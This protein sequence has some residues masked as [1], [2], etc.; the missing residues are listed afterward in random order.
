MAVGVMAVDQGT[1]STRAIIF[2]RSGLPIAWEQIEHRQIFPAP[3]WV[4]HDPAEIWN[5][6]RNVMG[7]ALAKSDLGLSDIAAVGITQQRETTLVWDKVSGNPVYNALVWQDTRT[8]ELCDQLADGDPHRFAAKTGLPLA[9]YFSG[10][11]I[12]WILDNVPGVRH[13]A[14]AG[15]LM[16][17][18]IDTW[19]LYAMTG[20]RVHATDPSNASRTLLMDLETGQWDPELCEAMQVPMGML[21][22]IRSSS[23]VFGKITSP[24]SM[25]GVP[26][27]GILGD[28]QAASFGQACLDPGMVKNTY[29]TGNFVLLNT[30]TTPVRSKNGLLTTVLYKLGDEP[31]VYAL[32]GSIA[33]TGSLVQWLRDNLG[34]VA[35]SDDV[36]E[37]AKTVRDNGDCYLVPAFSGLFA[38][39]WRADARGALVGLSRFINKGH[40]ARA[41]LESAAF[42]SREV[43]EAMAADSGVR[44]QSLKV[45]GGMVGNDLL[46]QFQADILGV[47][48]VRPKVAQTTALGAAYAAGLAVGFWESTDEIRENWA[49]DKRWQP[50]M[51][52]ERREA[53]YAR[54]QQA[55][56]RTFD[57]VDSDV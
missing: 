4:E 20:T 5:N 38:P 2:D 11:K 8:K 13:R 46:M 26:I 27:A 54:W 31:T 43:I 24:R 56:R 57:W 3:G 25:A 48:V 10:P 14:E 45:D 52:A 50:Q 15:D 23:G 18:T 6:T 7:A 55:V 1:T 30:G 22:E 51:P 53:L 36:E 19:L 32:E 12:R 40:I 16:C 28:Q 9:T 35:N 41:A 29:G 44:L 37:L 42:Q 39:Y 21:P 17:G 34:L 33:M 49:E 47:D